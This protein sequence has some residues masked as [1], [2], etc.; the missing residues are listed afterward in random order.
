MGYSIACRAQTAKL[1]RRMLDFMALQYRS[2]PL[3]STGKDGDCYAGA[4]TDDLSYDH[5]KR[6]VGIDYGACAGWEREY[7]Y[8]LVRWV[9]IQVG[10]R[11]TRFGGDIGTL[12][13]KYPVFVYDG[14]EKW[15]VMVCGDGRHTTKFDFD[16]VDS[17]LRWTATDRYGVRLLRCRLV[18]DT[19]F[20]LPLGPHEINQ[21]SLRA[22]EAAGPKEAPS[23]KGS[24]TWLG[25]YQ[26]ALAQDPQ[27]KAG[28]D[29]S[30]G[31]IRREM[32]RLTREWA[33]FNPHIGSSLDDFLK[34]N[35]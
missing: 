7:A 17:G 26:E 30:L 28:L 6:A 21:I 2:W 4:P 29:K 15:P 3:L 9:A 13:Q 25:R 14:H 12:K 16:R 10:T 22:S 1:Q 24:D 18:T 35:P 32:R 34:E 33:R 27:V 8:T 11:T 19:L 23:A 31:L 20:D 5:A